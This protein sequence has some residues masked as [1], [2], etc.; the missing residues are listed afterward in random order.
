MDLPNPTEQH[1]DL[2]A[3]SILGARRLPAGGGAGMGREEARQAAREV[4]QELQQIDEGMF[5][6]MSERYGVQIIAGWQEP[7][8]Y[9][10]V[11]D[12]VQWRTV[13]QINL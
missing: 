3:D 12:G 6:Y 13:E 11:W 5:P 8:L 7:V 1:V 4:W 2:L 10:Q 9:V